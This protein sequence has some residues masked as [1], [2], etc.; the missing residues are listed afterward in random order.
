MCQHLAHATSLKPHPSPIKA[1][2]TMSPGR[3]G[4]K[5][6]ARGHAAGTQTHAIHSTT[7]ASL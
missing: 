7:R 6:L 2:S 5:G 3:R 1:V 4:L